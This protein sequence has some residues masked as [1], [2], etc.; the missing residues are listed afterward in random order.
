LFILAPVVVTSQS[1]QPTNGQSQGPYPVTLQTRP[2]VGVVQTSYQSQPQQQNVQMPM[3]QL[4]FNAPYPPVSGNPGNPPYPTNST[5]PYPTSS[6]PSAPY[7]VNDNQN[8]PTYSQV[9][10]N[11]TNYNQQPPYNPSYK[12]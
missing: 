9:A 5:A 12:S 6:Q 7:P 4:G 1:F 10:G 8:P 2:S 11:P 3:P